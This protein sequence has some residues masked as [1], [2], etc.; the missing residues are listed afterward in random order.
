MMILC[1][2]CGA[3]FGVMLYRLGRKEGECGRVMPLLKSAKQTRQRDAL[4]SKIE[5][6]QGK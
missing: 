1:I 6:Y 3:V 5:N 4:L 2:M